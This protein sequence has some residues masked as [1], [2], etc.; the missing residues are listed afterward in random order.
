[1]P[2]VGFASVVAAEKTKIYSLDFKEKT[3]LLADR[4]GA[5]VA[6]KSN[7]S[8]V[9]ALPVELLWISYWYT[10]VQA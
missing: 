10:Y 9:L 7:M 5:P 6:V 3:V 8:A 2:L 4:I 1:M